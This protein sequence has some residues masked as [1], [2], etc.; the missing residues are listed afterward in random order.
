MEQKSISKGK[1]VITPSA[2]QHASAEYIFKK[3]KPKLQ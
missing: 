1:K 2:G 3:G